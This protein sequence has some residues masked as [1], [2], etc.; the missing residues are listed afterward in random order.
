M[1]TVR[2]IVS[3]NPSDALEGV[4]RTTSD[5]ARIAVIPGNPPDMPRTFA[6]TYLLVV[7]RSPRIGVPAGTVMGW[8]R[9]AA[10]K[11]YYD[12]CI[13]TR[14]DGKALSAPRQFTL[15]LTD[16]SH[17]SMTAVHD[18]VEIVA[19]KLLPYM[20]RRMLRERHDRQN[21]LDG[22]LRVWPVDYSDPIAP[23]YL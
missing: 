2:R 7:I 1:N 12:S 8:C 11:G 14:C 21:D 19:W 15:R 13:F 5:G 17:L 23:R 22:M 4:W 10:K 18:G 16:G 6:D 9:P 3:E 20:F